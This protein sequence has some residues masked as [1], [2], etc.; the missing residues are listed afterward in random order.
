[1][2]KYVKNTV[3]KLLILL[4]TLIVVLVGSLFILFKDDYFKAIVNSCRVIV[5]EDLINISKAYEDD[6]ETNVETIYTYTIVNLDGKIMKT[7]ED[8]TTRLYSFK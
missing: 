7:I 4:I 6:E 3:T 1:M 2:N 5:S 8:E